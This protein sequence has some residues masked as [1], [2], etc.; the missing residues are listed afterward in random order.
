MWSKSGGCLG[1]GVIA[2]GVELLGRR[3][4]IMCVEASLQKLG[5]VGAAAVL[6]FAS[7][8]RKPRGGEFIYCKPQA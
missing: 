5:G 8:P 2:A 7:L 1:D 3:S 6:S 4:C